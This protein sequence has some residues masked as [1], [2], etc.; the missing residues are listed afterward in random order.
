[1]RFGN[2]TAPYNKEIVK[3]VLTAGQ[4]LS[5]EKM[6]THAPPSTNDDMDTEWTTEIDCIDT[7]PVLTVESIMTAGQ[8]CKVAKNEYAC[9][10]VH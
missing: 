3:R 8:K 9:A 10:S 4:V 2:P 5:R 1:M 6:N 7:L